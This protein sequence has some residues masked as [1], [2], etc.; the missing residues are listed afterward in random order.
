MSVTTND[1][2]SRWRSLTA[3][4]IALATVYLADVENAL[5]VYAHD[6]GMDLDEMLEYG[7][8][9]NLYTA[10]VCDIVK[11]ELTALSDD[12]ALSQ[13]SQSVNGYNVQGTF[14]SPG[15]GLFIKNAELKLLGLLRQNAKAIELYD[16]EEEE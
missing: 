5:H 7:P 15:G 14:L 12:P 2:I 6:R 8:R 16:Y 4:E 1:L 10:I 13:Y 11:R 3:D 9:G